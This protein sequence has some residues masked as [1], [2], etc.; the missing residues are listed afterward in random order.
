M[1]VGSKTSLETSPLFTFLLAL[2][3]VDLRE[4][5]EEHGLGG[6]FARFY[7]QFQDEKTKNLFLKSRQQILQKNILFLD[8]FSRLNKKA[9]AELGRP[10]T[11]L[12]GLSLLQTVHDL[13]ERQMTDMDLYLHL[14]AENL[15]PFF[16]KDGYHLSK[17][18]KW[19]FNNHKWVFHKTTPLLDFTV[20][21]HTQLL[22]QDQKRIWETDASGRLLPEEEFLYLCAH[23]GQQHTCLKLFWL[24]DLYFF[25][26][27]H[28]HLDLDSLWKKAKKFHVHRSL[29]AAYWALKFNFNFDFSTQI[30]AKPQSPLL[31]L[32][33]QPKNLT[34]LFKNRWRYLLLKHLL[35]DSFYEAIS[36][37][38]KWLR[39]QVEKNASTIKSN[40]IDN[41]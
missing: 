35:K 22:P 2:P 21:V 8:E 32:L 9:C 41:L 26:L 20:E 27:K 24:M 5:S 25:C 17:E 40:F 13:G 34:Y 4:L 14:P 29:A 12:K 28:P 15:I 37:D 33:M 36:Y 10:L 19:Y 1:D 16:Q 39:F 23:W 7:K 11:P 18:K 38:V 3:E 6:L 30:E 31:Q